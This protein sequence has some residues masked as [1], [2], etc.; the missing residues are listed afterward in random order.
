MQLTSALR[1]AARRA[2]GDALSRPHTFD[3][4][5]IGAGAAGGLA[6]ELLTRRGLEV[7]VLDAGHWPGALRWAAGKAVSTVANPDALPFLPPGLLYKGRRALRLLGGLRQPVQTDCYAWERAPTAF[8]DDIDCPYSTPPGRPFVWIRA[9]TLGGRVV[10][11]GHGRQYFRFG[12]ADFASADGESPPWPLQPGELDRWY[13]V[14]ERRLHLSGRREGAPWLPDSEISRE[15]E[16]LPAEQD[17]MDRISARWPDAWPVLGRFAPPPDTLATAAE[18]GRLALRQGA[19][20]HG[21]KTDPAGRVRAVQWIDALTGERLEASAPVVFLCASCLE[22]TRIL[23]MSGLGGPSGALGRYLMDHVTIKVDGVGGRLPGPEAVRMEDGRNVYLPR[24]DARMGER[25]SSRGFGVQVYRTSIGGGRSFFT[26]V[27][28]S[29]MLPRARNHV[30]LDPIRKD[31]WGLPVLHIDC[32]HSRFE[33]RM[34]LSQAQALREL[35]DVAGI[36]VHHLSETPSVP[37]SAVHETGT[38]RMGRDPETSVLDPDNQCWA[39]R[40]LYVTDSSS[41]PSQGS[42]NPT[43][44]VMALTARACEHALQRGGES[45]SVPE[46]ALTPEMA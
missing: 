44:T 7:L 18:T 12:P 46:R 19:V 10:V 28:F 1:S 26:A 8:V 40:G 6:A 16:P 4:I 9:R 25:D 45:L 5:V 35:A 36:Q 43:L 27:A 11:P 41:F 24:F 14:A 37:G 21:I 22:S 13:A 32:A 39:A 31:R 33:R 20:V 3:A 2:S 17:L 30:R 29:E 15:L 23:M 42:Q 34:A 38:A